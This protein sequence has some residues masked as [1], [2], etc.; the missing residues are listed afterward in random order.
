MTSVEFYATIGNHD[1]PNQPHYAPFNMGGQRYYTFMADGSLLARLTD[2][3]VRFFMVDTEALDRTQLAW[4]DRELGR[5]RRALEHSGLSSA[6]LHVGAVPAAGA[7]P[8]CRRSSR[9]SC[10]TMSALALSGHEHFY[11]RTEPQRGITYFIS[12]GA[13]SLRRGDMRRSR[14][15][16]TASTPTITSCCS[17]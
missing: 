6:D 14:L 17:R 7:D 1:D 12:G 15:T 9:C 8:A 4:L 11:Q 3:D 13:G 5:S 2:T 10:A 16:A